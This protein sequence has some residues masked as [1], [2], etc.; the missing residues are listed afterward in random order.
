M[1]QS[2]DAALWCAIAGGHVEQGA[3]RKTAT[4]QL[5]NPLLNWLLR[6]DRRALLGPKP[7]RKVRR[8]R[9]K[10]SDAGTKRKRVELS[11]EEMSW[12]RERQG[13]EETRLR[14]HKVIR[15]QAVQKHR[16]GVAN[17]RAWFAANPKSEG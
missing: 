15:R 6:G 11:A 5:P 17:G 1:G 4:C 3:L 7:P 8:V 13:A 10:R 14:K 2:E 12:V 16:V 9:K